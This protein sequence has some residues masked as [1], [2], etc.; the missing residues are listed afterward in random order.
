MSHT[1]KA[2]QASR[3]AKLLK[4]EL[5]NISKRDSNLLCVSLFLGR[6]N[7]MPQ[8][9]KKKT[10]LKHVQIMFFPSLPYQLGRLEIN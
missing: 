6:E 8:V 2:A 4:D 9:R 3:K 5:A 7:V 1:Q 10:T